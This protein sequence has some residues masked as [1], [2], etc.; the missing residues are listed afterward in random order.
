MQNKEKDYKM[1]Q[2]I[3]ELRQKLQHDF[4]QTTTDYSDEDDYPVVV[5]KEMVDIT[6]N[7][8][9]ENLLQLFNELDHTLDK[10][11]IDTN[12]KYDMVSNEIQVENNNNERNLDIYQSTSEIIHRNIMSSTEEIQALISQIYANTTIIIHTGDSLE[13]ANKAKYKLTIAKKSM[14]IMDSY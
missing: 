12:L 8:S 6:I 11:L 10:Y 1:D 5:G 7:V 13:Y 2:T 3:A 14:E 9:E 4:T